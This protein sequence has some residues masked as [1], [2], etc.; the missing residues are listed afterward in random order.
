MKTRIRSNKNGRRR[1]GSTLIALC[2]MMIVAISNG[3][4]SAGTGNQARSVPGQL[5]SGPERGTSATGMTPGS[6]GGPLEAKFVNVGQGDCCE[7]KIRD[8]T[9]YFFAVIDTGPRDAASTVVDELKKMGCSTVNVLVLSHPDADHTGGATAL[10]ENFKVLQEW[11]PGSSK[12]TATWNQTVDM[13][14]A[15][16]IPRVNPV[17][18]YTAS[19][20][21][22][23]VD[24]LGPDS[25]TAQGAGADVNDA[26]LVMSVSVGHDGILFTGDAGVNEQARMMGETI[27]PIEV[28]KVPHHGGKS[29]YYAPFLSKVAPEMS[30]IDVGVNTYGHPSPQVVSALSAY[31]AV[32]ETKVNGD[33]EVEETGTTI[34]IKPQSGAGR[35]LPP[36]AGNGG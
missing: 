7:I 26:C 25:G 35:Q 29:C 5:A 20:G 13:I 30:V 24:V 32:Y 19:W 14:K 16:A 4:T 27:P 34:D 33:I 36:K 12:N 22:A 23:S 1:A 21:P 9:G 3:C 15:K 31:G 17:T 2:L 10:M 11:D 18:G 28:Y 6:G 8:G